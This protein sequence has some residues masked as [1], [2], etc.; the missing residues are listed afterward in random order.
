MLYLSSE[1]VKEK[2]D[3]ILSKFNLPTYIEFNH[4]EVLDYIT[5][6]KKASGN[7]ISVV[8]VENVGSFEFRTLDVLEIKKIIGGVIHE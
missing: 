6:D 4:D 7:K 5:H 3:K 1:N 2:I 8:F